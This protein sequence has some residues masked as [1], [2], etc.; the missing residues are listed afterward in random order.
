M[1][2]TDAE[3]SIALNSGDEKVFEFIFKTYY[4]RLCNYA[5]SILHDEDES[6]EI[7]QSIFLKIW[8]KRMEFTVV[9]SFKSYIYRTVYN[10]C[11]NKI[12]HDKV[13]QDYKTE[14]Q[15]ISS[16]AIESTGKKIMGKELELLIASA[17]EKLPEQCR[18]VFK[19][20]RF[21]ELKY[22]EISTHLGISIKTV[23]NHMGKALKILREELKDYLPLLILLLPWLF[24]L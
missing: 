24:K 18:L 6:E 12:R 22:S 14:L 8:E 20:S 7:V 4:N 9:N 1:E 5:D 2:L 16:P 11:M 19:L 10:A 17:I 3:I 15:A 13:R 21:E 23:E